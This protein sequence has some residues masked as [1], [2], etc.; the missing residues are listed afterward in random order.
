M[1]KYTYLLLDCDGTLFDFKRAEQKAFSRLLHY[2]KIEEKEEYFS[3]YH[4][5][6]DKCWKAFEQGE[7][8]KDVLQFKRFDDFRQ[9]IDRDFS[10]VNAAKQYKEFLSEGYDL[11]PGAEEVCRILSAKYE[12]YLV[13]NGV[14]KTQVN[15]LNHSGLLPYIK[16]MFVSEAVGIPKPDIGYFNYV[17]SQIPSF[18]K[19]RALIVGDSLTSDIQ[20]GINA[21]I[22]TCW[23]HSDGQNC[24]D[25]MNITY[26]ITDI[27]QLV[28]LLES[29]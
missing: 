24:P 12:L 25:N 4:T 3:I 7:L 10:T 27:R 19:G 11:L 13:T 28:S 23:L 26:T 18:E 16:R 8:S 6:N 29:L 20:G 5:I 15:R 1:N 2:L 22:D 17:F 21:G 9:A 14:E